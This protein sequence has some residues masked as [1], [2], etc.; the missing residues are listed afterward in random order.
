MCINFAPIGARRRSANKARKKN[1]EGED[2]N[3]F[4]PSIL[5]DLGVLARNLISSL[6][7]PILDTSVPQDLPQSAESAGEGGTR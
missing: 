5:S 7:L 1:S 4:T 3:T 2:E 6:G